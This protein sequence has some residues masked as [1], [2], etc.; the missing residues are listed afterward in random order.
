MFFCLSSC[1]ASNL[2]ASKL[3]LIAVLCGLTRLIAKLACLRE[4]VVPDVQRIA[5]LLQEH[6]AVLE[7]PP[8]EWY[9]ETFKTMR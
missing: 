2:F 7:L 3:R 5:G 1:C 4:Q 6:A 8:T 9:T